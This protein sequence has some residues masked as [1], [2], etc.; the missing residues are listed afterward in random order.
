MREDWIA[1]GR[2][3]HRPGLHAV[4]V[5]RLGRWQMG[6]PRPLR[7]PVAMVYGALY[8]VTRNL[9][10]IE[11]PRQA[12]VGRRFRIGHQGGIVISE[13]AQIGD[14]CLI[15]QN[16]TVG[17]S[18]QGGGAAPRIGDRVEF[19]VSAV[20][21]GD[22]TVGDDALVGPNTVVTVD[23]PPGARVV[24]S[25][26]RIMVPSVG[27]GGGS[28]GEHATTGESRLAPVDGITV[29][30]VMR[31]IRDCAGIDRIAP[32]TPLLSSGLV[33][34]LTLVVVLEG[35]ESAFGV[36]LDAQRVDASS[37]DTPT[38][39]LAFLAPDRQP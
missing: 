4:L 36:Q 14:D 5:Y 34:S 23:V 24:A 1:N 2:Q 18:R 13:L 12:Q 9:Y 20:V 32:D 16:V 17:V 35:L 27:A 7:I 10:G 30:D 33:D 21:L 28:D 25:P 39:M 19:G 26:S 38:Q 8:F 29:T 37:F 31:V 11:L 3:W 15:R 22:I 6:L